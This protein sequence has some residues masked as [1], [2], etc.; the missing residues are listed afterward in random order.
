MNVAPVI[1]LPRR[2]AT[3]PGGRFPSGTSPMETK[4]RM[5]SAGKVMPSKKIALT[6]PVSGGQKMHAKPHPSWYVKSSN[7]ARP[8]NGSASNTAPVR[9]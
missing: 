4:P 5:L 7:N 3:A 1:G 8:A 9:R 6:A 2:P